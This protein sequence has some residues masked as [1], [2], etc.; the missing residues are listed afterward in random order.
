MGVSAVDVLYMKIFIYLIYYVFQRF[1][2]TVE[3]RYLI[4]FFFFIIRN[5]K[6]MIL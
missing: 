1:E 2:K 5:W 6:I 3:N 4:S